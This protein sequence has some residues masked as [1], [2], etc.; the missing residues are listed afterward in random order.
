[1]GDAR[2]SFWLDALRF[3]SEFLEVSI[4]GAPGWRHLLK[5]L[6]LLQHNR[7]RD[8]LAELC[9]AETS[10]NL[11]CAGAASAYRAQASFHLHDPAQGNSTLDRAEAILLQ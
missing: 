8:A 2:E 9:E 7:P 10:Y 3:E 11:H 1:M 4:P 5:G 6:M